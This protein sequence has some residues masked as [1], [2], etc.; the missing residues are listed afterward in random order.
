MKL[1]F[2]TFLCFLLLGQGLSADPSAGDPLEIREYVRKLFR[3]TGR[4]FSFSPEVMGA[5]SVDEVEKG[6]TSLEGRLCRALL[7]VGASCRLEGGVY[8]IV[9]GE[10][11]L[12]RVEGHRWSPPHEQT[13]S[14]HWAVTQDSKELWI[15]RG[16]SLHRVRKSD[17]KTLSQSLFWDEVERQKVTLKA[18]SLDLREVLRSLF[19]Q[20]DR[21]FSISPEVKGKVTISVVD[22]TFID[23]L[24][25]V[26]RQVNAKYE[27]DGG[28]YLINPIRVPKEPLNKEQNT[29]RFV[30][31]DPSLLT[32]WSRGSVIA[33]DESFMY[34]LIDQML[35]KLDKT[36]LQQIASRRMGE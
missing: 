11:I 27:I 5:V 22:G 20:V 21:S 34:V 19:K 33:R 32:D 7:L 9:P 15:L 16:K 29:G 10:A 28:V 17:L 26:L 8:N 30:D 31:S 24:E 6:E 25:T 36:S 18:N 14:S 13:A 12:L 23:A 35:Y 3:G 4:S 2:S 1:L